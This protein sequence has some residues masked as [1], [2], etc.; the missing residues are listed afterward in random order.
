MGVLT[1]ERLPY[2]WVGQPIRRSFDL[3][4]ITAGT[5]PSKANILVNEIFDGAHYAVLPG[6]GVPPPTP[7]PTRAIL[8]VLRF[9]PNPPAVHHLAN[10]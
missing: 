2:D 4:T 6:D 1:G 5:A 7:T 8:V 9:V 10:R 3:R